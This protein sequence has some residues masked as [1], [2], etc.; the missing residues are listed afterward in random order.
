MRG[1]PR[2][3]KKLLFISFAEHAVHLIERG[4]VGVKVLAVHLVLRDA[5][6]IID[7]LPPLLLQKID[8]NNRKITQT[9]KRCIKKARKYW[10]F[11]FFRK[12][13]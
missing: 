7:N 10:L 12:R 8:K 5:Q 4:V 2:T 11:A 13:A 3:V 1:V 9:S 6:G